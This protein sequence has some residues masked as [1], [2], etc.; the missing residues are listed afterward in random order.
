MWDINKINEYIKNQI[1][2]NLHL[3]YKAAA[4]LGK[5]D[6]KK[7]EISKDVSAFANSDGGVIIYGIS[8]FNEPEKSHLPEKIDPINRTEY[9]KEWLEQVI[10]SNI[11]P[12]IKGIKIFPIQIGEPEDNKSI[13]VVEIPQSDT[14]HQ[15]KDRRYYK[16]YNFESVAMEDYEIKDIINRTNKTDIIISFEPDI[17][18]EWYNKFIQDDTSFKI[19]TTIWAYNNGNNVTRFLQVFI[20][21]KG[22]V[23]DYII[24]PY[25]K[26]GKKFQLIFSNEEKRKIIL[27][28]EEFIIGIERIPILPN[29]SRMIGT[30]EFYS[31]IIKKDME[32]NIQISTEDRSKF[33][34]LKGKEII[35]GK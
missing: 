27:K 22:E 32:L 34:T 18:K 21:G 19:S 33:V 6:P 8:E 25:T 17:G 2:E 14:A 11:S 30:L 9:S 7:K 15:A 10:N 13:Y 3:D 24:E 1:E 23:A 31:D 28:D 4:S 16:R 29:T 20:S 5:S 26:K 35:E 12:K